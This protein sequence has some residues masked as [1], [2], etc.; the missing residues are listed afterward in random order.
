VT[1]PAGNRHIFIAMSYDY[2]DWL[3]ERQQQK[4]AEREAQELDDE[5]ESEKE[6]EN[7]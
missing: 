6:K 1:H 3:E 5:I 2:N 7:K 4:D